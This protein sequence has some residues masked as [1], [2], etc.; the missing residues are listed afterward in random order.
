MLKKATL[1]TKVMLTIMN[2]G[3]NKLC[4]P[5]KRF[6]SLCNQELKDN[7]ENYPG[8]LYCTTCLSLPHEAVKVY[9]TGYEGN[10]YKPCVDK[11]II[12]TDYFRDRNKAK[13]ELKLKASLL[14]CNV[15]YNV[16]F[17]QKKKYSG[18]YIYSVWKAQGM[19]A[20]KVN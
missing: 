13:F 11:E 18:N 12:L 3:W 8:N 6:C 16:S 17:D 7:V 15:V 4:E 19:A 5:P 14:D 2:V 1:A 20:K 9:P 10:C